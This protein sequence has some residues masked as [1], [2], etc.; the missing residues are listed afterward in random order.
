M[1]AMGVHGRWMFQ[2]EIGSARGGVR[3]SWRFRK[4]HVIIKV[5]SMGGGGLEREMLS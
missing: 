2:M 5:E 3:R 4:R 1:D